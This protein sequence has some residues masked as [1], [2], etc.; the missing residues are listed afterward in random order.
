[1][2]AVDDKLLALPALGKLAQAARRDGKAI[3]LCHGVF[4]VLHFGHLKHFE[5]AKRECDV[6][7]VTITADEFV[8]KGPGRPYFPTLM[9]AR[10]LAS[11]EFIDGVGVV[12]EATALPAIET[13]RPDVYVKGADYQNADDDV[14]GKIDQEREAVEKAG[15]RLHHT[16]EVTFSSSS[17]INAFLEDYEPALRDCLHNMRETNGLER[18][19]GLI[20][21]AGTLKVLVVGDAIIDEY[22][23]VATLGKSAKEH[24][25][26]TLAKDREQYAGG[27]FAIANHLAGFCDAVEIVTTF[28]S[29]NDFEGMVREK[30]VDNVE[31]CSLTVDGRPTTR[32]TRY[33]DEGHSRKLFEVYDMDDQPLPSKQQAQTDEW[34]SEKAHTA[35]LVV[36]CDFGH[37]L[38]APSTVEILEREAKFLAVNVQ[39]NAGNQGFNHITKF[40]RADLVCV[41]APEARI[42]IKEKFLPLE[43]IISE[44]LPDHIDCPF[45]VITHG[46]EGCFVHQRDHEVVHIPAFTRSVVDT[47]GAGDAFFSVAAPLSAAGGA[48]AEVGFAANAAGA[49]KVGVVGNRKPIDRVSVIKYI[50]ALLS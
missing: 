32:K 37:G 13:V 41:D 27:V 10:M 11:L 4:D 3:G 20:E 17:L 19:T 6:L 1:M 24:I 39:T 36:V 44:I 16:G 5:A 30:M 7:F 38:I 50:T 9:R 33:V 21:K 47:V 42:A 26:A 49:L 23:F 40:S 25:I 14:T 43:T 48:P 29:E 31:L 34:V 18:L 2:I 28:G 45:F 12:E 35:D 22:R 46:A 8:R 15:G